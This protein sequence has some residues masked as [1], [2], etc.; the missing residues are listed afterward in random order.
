MQPEAFLSRCLLLDIETNENGRV[1]AIG[2][3]IGER[4]FRRTER[5]DTHQA[6]LDLDS[7][8]Y[9]AE[10]L[11]GHNLLR[12][13]LP[14]LRALAPSLRFLTKP[15]VDTLYLSPLAFPQNPYHRLV[16]DYKLVRDTLNDPVADARLAAGLFCDQWA[17][18]ILMQ[19]HEARL[20]SLYSYCFKGNGIFAGLHAAWAAMGADQITLAEASEWFRAL[21]QGKACNS[22]VDQIAVECL[23]DP[24]LSPALAYC[25]AWLRVAGG[26]S[27]LPPWVRHQFPNV[28][29]LLHRMRDIP[30]SFSTC[31]YCQET[32]DPTTQLQRFFGLPTFRPKPA[33]SD[34]SSLQYAIAQHAMADRPMLAMLPTGAGKSLC[35][36]LPALVRYL[37]RGVLTVVISPLQALMKDQVD[38]LRNRTGVPNAAAL[39]GL[40]TAPERGEVLNGIRLGDV[41][42]LYVSPE[43][44]RNRSFREAIGY[45]EIGAWVFDEAHCLSKWGHDFRPDYLYAARFIKEFAAKQG[46]EVP[47]VQCFTAT[48]KQD[49][50]AEILDYF[51][52]VLGQELTVFEGGVERSNL[53]FEVQLVSPHEK[54]QR[55]HDIL[56]EN[57][58]SNGTGCAIIYCAT[59]A[60]T[61]V[62]AEYLAKQ[63]RQAEAFHAGLPAPRKKHIQDNFIAGI[64]QVICATTAFG[65]GIDKEDVRLVIHADIPGSLENYLQEAGRAGRDQRDARCILL[66]NE[67]DAETQFKMTARSQLSRKDIAQILRGL[68]RAKRNQADDIVITVGELLRTEDIQTSF[69]IEDRQATTRVITAVA[70]LERAAFLQRNENRTQVF[71]GRPLVETLE[72][73]SDR[74][75]KLGLSKRQRAR[76]LAILEMLM[77][78]TADE[79]LS[80]DQIAEHTAFKPDTATDSE[81]DSNG[82]ESQRVLR[83]LHAMAEA[84]LIQKSLMLSAYVRYKVAKHS[85]L[86]LERIGRIEEAM[87]DV[88]MEEAPDAGVE[89]WQTL[90]LRRLNQRL[91]DQ[92]YPDSNPNLLCNL[93]HSLSLDSKGCGGSRDGLDFRYCGMNAYQVRLQRDWNAL[94]VTAQRRRMVAAIVLGAIMARIPGDAPASAELLVDFSAE[95]LMA[96]LKQDMVAAS[97]IKD[98]LAAIDRALMFLHDQRIITLQ[99]GLTVFRQAMTIRIIPEGKR[100]SYSKGDYEPLQCHYNERT[101]QVHVMN[102]YARKGLEEIRQALALM[103]AYFS[104]DKATFVRRFFADRQEMLERATSQQSFERIVEALQNPVQAAIVAAPEDRNMLILAGP[105]SGKSR[106][107]VHRCA[108]LIRVL[109]VLPR[110]ILVLCFNHNAAISLR[111]RLRELIGD[112]AKGVMVLTY[113]GLALRLTG[114]SLAVR[115]TT[116]GQHELDFDAMISEAVELLRGNRE[117]VDLVPDEVRDRLLAGY[118]HILVDE[119]QDIDQRQY[120]LI[121]ALA[122]RTLEDADSKLNLLAVGDDDQNI[123]RFR[124]A[125][126]DF[127][128]RFQSD[129]QAD[130][131]YLIDNYRSSL[132]IISAANRLI[133]DNRDRMKTDY[134]IQINRTRAGL[135]PGGRWERLDPLAKGRVSCLQVRNGTEQAEAAILELE[136]LRQCDGGF[137]WSDCAV[138]ASTNE[139]LALERSLCEN[140][141]IPF[142]WTLPPDCVP[143]PFRIRENR[144][145]LDRLIDAKG[146]TVKASELIVYLDKRLSEEPRN[147]WWQHLRL[148]LEDWRDETG[149]GLIPVTQTLD[150][151]SEALAEQRRDRRLGHGLFLST[152]HSAKGMEFKHV[153]ILDGGF[154]RGKSREEREEERRLYYV[155]MARARETLCLVQRKDADNPFLARLDGNFLLKRTH[156][157]LLRVDASATA[158]RYSVL[159]LHDLYL[160]F[161]GMYHSDNPIHS[162]LANLRPGSPLHFMRDGQRIRLG[163][164]E[165]AVAALSKTAYETWRDRLDRIESVRVLAMIRWSRDDGDPHYSRSCQADSWEVPM[166]E[167]VHLAELR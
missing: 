103:L 17:S 14:V 49:V 3:V 91:L 161:A 100:R 12:H 125:N 1:Y 134:P 5:F 143:P 93:L 156:E 160:D 46:T 135:P 148:L 33:A 69:S 138:L 48:A 117:I 13:D 120:D 7:F 70:W 114:H 57:L 41:A 96:A 26:N 18:F 44:L 51:L 106:T 163:D 76:W 52:K 9:E 29:P 37:R 50:K 101:F 30:C 21:M 28:A 132:H 98:S 154:G 127:I 55:L 10:Y 43:Q 97:Q 25:I 22:A 53:S 105:G 78:A 151:L 155:A 129:Y 141:R 56:S 19:R 128:R 32:H 34:G 131:N 122:G 111:R 107:V 20:L 80:A 121:S 104:E 89:D 36:Q 157:G 2:S 68:R 81:D 90:S 27:V 6:L 167:V 110:S 137:D 99:K 92:D 112:D 130:V 58:P 83:T 166:V 88:L 85:L 39:Y 63:G 54:L 77:N 152:I 42:L 149:D 8:G 66:Y 79:G 145:V 159:G 94:R 142:S 115:T 40:L 164:G 133:A 11:L 136:R 153:V 162:R 62:V 87:I 61:E 147:P 116:A 60:G 123:Y 158:K 65:M 139:L 95:D 31:D 15:V 113:H 108:Y 16:K 24:E 23:T 35:Y 74:I 126:V 71:Q 102:E 144:I 109:R 67:D 84:R 72:E 59:Q 124:G 45:R 82:T 73:A 165:T 38:N 47:P 119:Y 64:T 150:F 75:D 118:R 4:V 146:G 86:M 140:R